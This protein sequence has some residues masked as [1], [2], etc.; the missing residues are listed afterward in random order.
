M[1]KNLDEAVHFQFEKIQE[2]IREVRGERLQGIAKGR[3][4][5]P[6]LANSLAALFPGQIS[7]REFIVA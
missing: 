3:S 1:S 2:W 4:S 7:V 6:R 5:N